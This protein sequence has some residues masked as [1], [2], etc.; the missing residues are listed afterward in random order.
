MLASASAIKHKSKKSGLKSGNIV[1]EGTL[2]RP[3]RAVL[4]AAVAM[5]DCRRTVDAS[6]MKWT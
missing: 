1:E 2:A 3:R 5:Q 6:D 4:R